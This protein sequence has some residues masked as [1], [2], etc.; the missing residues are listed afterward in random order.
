MGDR[1]A[2]LTSV[3]SA[4]TK[5]EF[6]LWKSSCLDAGDDDDSEYI[7]Q[8]GLEFMDGLIAVQCNQFSRCLLVNINTSEQLTGQLVWTLTAPKPY[9]LVSDPP[10]HKEVFGK[11][12]TLTDLARATRCN[13]VDDEPNV[14]SMLRANM[15]MTSSEKVQAV[16]FAALE[17]MARSATVPRYLT[18]QEQEMPV[19][20]W[21]LCD[22]DLQT[23]PG[24]LQFLNLLGKANEQSISPMDAIL[25][26]CHAMGLLSLPP[27]NTEE[28]LLRAQAEPCV[29]ITYSPALMFHMDDSPENKAVFLGHTNTA[30]IHSRNITA[31]SSYKIFMQQKLIS[32]KVQGEAIVKRVVA[33]LER[34]FGK[35][36]VLA[37]SV[38]VGQSANQMCSNRLLYHL[39]PGATICSVEHL[40]SHTL[41]TACKTCSA[42][43]Q[44]RPMLPFAVLNCFGLP[45]RRRF[46]WLDICKMSFRTPDTSATTKKLSEI[47][48]FSFDSKLAH[49]FG[50][51]DIAAVEAQK[52]SNIVDHPITELGT[53]IHKHDPGSMDVLKLVPI[54]DV[55]M[56]TYTPA[57]SDSSRESFLSFMHTSG[58]HTEPEAAAAATAPKVRI[59][60]E[61]APLFLKYVTSRRGHK[62]GTRCTETT[63]PEAFGHELKSFLKT[64]M[65]AELPQVARLF[66]EEFKGKA[67]PVVKYVI[68]KSW[69]CLSD[70]KEVHRHNKCWM[71]VS[72]YRITLRDLHP[73]C[74]P[75]AER[76]L[77]PPE[78]K[79]KMFIRLPK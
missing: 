48:L 20:S 6:N 75:K 12:R 58:M 78:V 43:V 77:T 26:E 57:D 76:I 4:R 55:A 62:H 67:V 50:I 68:S 5:S 35:D 37:R 16:H 52:M 49:E 10:V 42:H 25:L 51:G 71:F 59:P 39:K 1:F 66:Y 34:V 11:H 2:T 65:T 41:R 7:E 23:S 54:D 46:D 73:R 19:Y 3:V 18:L 56:T 47:P 27:L 8:S 74:K 70:P 29:F 45:I 79:Q 40:K 28:D 69:R 22:I 36:N 21:W 31:R 15:R 38:D 9:V 30:G 61:N 63:V 33:R 32:A 64:T 44:R 72:P 24:D 13:S 60:D 14:T 17:H 53:W